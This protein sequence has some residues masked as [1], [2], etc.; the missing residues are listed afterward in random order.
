MGRSTL[1]PAPQPAPLPTRP[2]LSPDVLVHPPAADGAPWV[3][4]LGGRRYFRVG[5][6]VAK[7]AQHLTGEYDLPQ[8]TT[9]L[10][11]P[12]TP[13]VLDQV[14]RQLGAMKLLDDGGPRATTPSR[15][16]FVPPMTVQFTVLNPS[17]LLDRMGGLLRLLAA[18]ATLVCLAL[19]AGGGIITLAAQSGTLARLASS[20]VTPL[21]FAVLF[22][23]NFATTILHEMC[24][25]AV[26][27]HHGGKARRMGFMLFY[28]VPAFFCDVSDGWRLP[29]AA[30]RVRVALAGI[31]AQL[32]VAGTVAL[33]SLVVPDRAAADALLLLSL[34]IYVAASMNIV[35][36]VKFDGYLALMSHLDVSDL[37]E[38]AMA[39]ARS[40]LA[41]ILLGAAPAPRQVPGRRWVVPYGLLC[42]VFP[43]FLVGVVG[44]HLW[45]DVLARMGYVG[46]LLNASLLGMLVVGVARELFRIVRLAG[47]V[48]GLRAAAAGTVLVAA[49]GVL[50]TQVHVTRTVP[51]VYTVADGRA[52]LYVAS[53]GEADQVGEGQRVVLKKNGILWRPATG[54]AEVASGERSAQTSL[55]AFMPVATDV[56]LVRDVPAFDLAV[57][58]LPAGSSG[59]ADVV[60]GDRDLGRWLYDTYLARL[61]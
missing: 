35:P 47:R 45:S 15:V 56:D 4:E 16:A 9:V 39:D 7:V 28:L 27:A 2:R 14:V 32:V 48:N 26:L 30:M 3:M 23:G 25:G 54:S 13:G 10:G 38:K 12:W 1:A 44:M 19:L 58:E 6:D 22:V 20:P 51:A 24:H 17:V 42:L 41:R 52:S 57:H 33:S 21:T 29:R 60:V 55:T 49:T 43:V 61:W 5:A 37:R 11:R 46:A 50:L 36:F 8:L 59:V 18:R 31:A 34:A 40:F 53:Q